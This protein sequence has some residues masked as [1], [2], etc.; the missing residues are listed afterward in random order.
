MEQQKQLF[1]IQQLSNRLNIPKPTLRFW[2][3]ELE[4]IFVPHRTQG[5]QRR[6]TEEHIGTIEEIKK[7]KNK[8]M[9]L[10]DIKRTFHNRR[11]E[12][13]PNAARIDLLLDRITEVVKAE[14]SNFFEKE[15][16]KSKVFKID[17]R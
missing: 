2:E 1:T 8:G 10:M 12:G 5:G 14:I 4:G 7:L 9:S 11:E 17:E 6:Y 16:L 3:K 15:R 13:D